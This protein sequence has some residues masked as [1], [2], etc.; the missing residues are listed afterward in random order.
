M[1]NKVSGRQIIITRI[2]DAPRDL[3]FKLWTDP[4][5][6]A[7]W[8]GPKDFTNP[9]CKMDV[10]PGGEWVQVMRG[11][12]GTEYPGRSIFLEVDAPKLLVY[13]D[14]A[15]DSDA[16]DEHLPEVINTVTFEEQANG[17]TKLTILTQLKSRTDKATMT[18]LG[19]STGMNQSLDR[20]ERYVR[21][22]G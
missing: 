3:V 22:T 5:H 21:S 17:T 7:Q 8:W 15:D 1:N 18:K 11:P 6:V 10:R 19:Y 4:Q 12:D 16:R 14:A 2:V 13:K 9:V 20:L